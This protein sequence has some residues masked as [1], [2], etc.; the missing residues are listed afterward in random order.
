MSRRCGPPTP[1]PHPVG[2]TSRRL[3]DGGAHAARTRPE[4][5]P[6]WGNPPYSLQGPRATTGRISAPQPTLLVW[7]RPRLAG[8]Q[9]QNS[10]YCPLSADLSL[11]Q[12]SEDLAREELEIPQTGRREL[13]G[14]LGG[15]GGEGLGEQWGWGWSLEAGQ[16]GR[17]GERRRGLPRATVPR[18]AQTFQLFSWV[19]VLSD[20][21]WPEFTPG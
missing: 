6:N 13:K 16:V 14:R 7:N 17:R 11:L 21:P 3:L 18:L 15:G 10:P 4:A 8:K 2:G 19:I 9:H 1:T 5:C 12:Y 20:F